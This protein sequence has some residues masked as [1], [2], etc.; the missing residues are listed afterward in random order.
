MIRIDVGAQKAWAHGNRL[1]HRRPHSPG[2]GGRHRRRARS[3][4]FH[5]PMGLHRM[6]LSLLP[7]AGSVRFAMPPR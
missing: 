2:L 6:L 5:D 3:L 1:I 4:L 7:D